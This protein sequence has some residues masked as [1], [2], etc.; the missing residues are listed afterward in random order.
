M[1][2]ERCLNPNDPERDP[3]ARAGREYAVRAAAAAAA[4]AAPRFYTSNGRTWTTMKG[5]QDEDGTQTTR[6]THVLARSLA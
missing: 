1:G 6:R 3:A 4:A 5:D 2:F